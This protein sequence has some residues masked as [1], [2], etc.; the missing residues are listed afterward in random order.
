MPKSDVRRVLIVAS[1][2]G[3]W[4]QMRRLRGAFEGLDV[5]YVTTRAD[6]AIDVPGA[7]FYAVPEMTRA[8]LGKLPEVVFRMCMIVIKERPDVVATTGAAPGL[9]ALIAGRFLVGAKTLWI[10]S[11]A[12]CERLSSS[13][14]SARRFADGWVT[15]WPDLSRPDGPDYWGSVI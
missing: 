14:K 11:I 9:I 15:Q 1:G 7:R 12:N 5:A 6:Y 8:N 3:H 2:G 13:G 10:D 4:I